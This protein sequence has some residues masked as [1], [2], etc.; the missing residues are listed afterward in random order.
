[1]GNEVIAEDILIETFVDV[2]RNAGRFEG[3]GQV[4]ALIRA[5][6]HFKALFWLR[7]CDDES[8]GGRAAATIGKGL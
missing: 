5:I 7:G 2:W 8:F 4:S 3:N 6:A 1:V